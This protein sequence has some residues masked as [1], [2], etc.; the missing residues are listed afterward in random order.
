MKKILIN[1]ATILVLVLFAAS[2]TNE[3][4]TPES[5]A[6]VS[7]ISSEKSEEVIPE[8]D[9][10]QTIHAEP[11]DEADFEDEVNYESV[12]VPEDSCLSNKPFMTVSID[13]IS[14]HYSDLE[15]TISEERANGHFI[16]LHRDGITYVS[17]SAAH[18]NIIGLIIDSNNYSLSCGI[19][20]GMSES[21][22]AKEF[23]FMDKY[24]KEDILKGEGRCA[25]IF[26]SMLLSDKMSPLN[27][28]DYDSAYAYITAPG[29]DERLKYDSSYTI[30]Y[31]IIAL[32][33]DK[34]VNKIILDMP[35]AN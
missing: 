4:E 21:T 25:M 3:A 30:P 12:F 27:N 8:S 20:S 26:D 17:H 19:K 11:A 14:K 16:F 5:S 15:E 29:E 9:D 6:S 1:V 13:D 2:C 31:T 28:T 34:K 35:T 10:I 24:T 22:L 33:K 7:G 18:G 32:I 23:S